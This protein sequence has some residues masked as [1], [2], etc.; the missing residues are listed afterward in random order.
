MGDTDTVRA[1]ALIR[2]RVQGVYFRASTAQEARSLGVRG[3]VRNVGDDVEAVFEG[4]RALVE[5][6][7]A[8]SHDGPPRA[9]VDR[10]DVEWEEPQAITGFSL[11][12]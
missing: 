10:V 6:M 11:R 4:P 1:H 2:G 5:R 7:L 8:W 3:W 12:S 9:S